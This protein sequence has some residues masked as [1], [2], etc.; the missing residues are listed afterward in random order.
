MLDE[1]YQEEREKKQ[2]MEV[3]IY[4]SRFFSIMFLLPATNQTREESKLAL[5]CT[6]PNF[7]ISFP[8]WFDS[9]NQKH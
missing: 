9:V 1:D 5:I 8:L 6:L 3:F 2:I 7:K 4:L